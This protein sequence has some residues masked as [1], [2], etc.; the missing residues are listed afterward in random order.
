M[1]VSKR[2][3]KASLTFIER[4]T[5]SDFQIR[6]RSI[7]EGMHQNPDYPNPP[8]R[9][10][11]FKAALDKYEQANAAALDRGK[12]ALAER[13]SQ[14]AVVGSMVRQLGHYVEIA[15]ADDESKFLPSGFKPVSSATRRAEPPPQPTI[16]NI[17]HGP[18][19]GELLVSPTSHYR[20]VRHFRIRYRIDA[21]NP[22][23]DESWTEIMAT[24]SRPATLV[25]GLKPGVLYTFQVRAFGNDGTFSDWSDPASLMCV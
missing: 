5:H 17:K 6:A 3:I 24:S 16:K 20:K 11:E 14:R 4:S 10:D 7:Y 12:L 18:H 15:A 9:M 2:R 23:L 8:L 25:A 13:A 19:S 1:G 21:D 22:E